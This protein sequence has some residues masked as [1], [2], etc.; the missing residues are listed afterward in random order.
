M[1]IELLCTALAYLVGCF[2]K[3]IKNSCFGWLL[4]SHQAKQGA[5]TIQR[6]V[7]L[8]DLAYCF[9]WLRQ[10]KQLTKSSHG[11]MHNWSETHGSSTNGSTFGPK[12]KVYLW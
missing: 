6:I 3:A 10:A 11:V 12:D 9:G 5:K 8:V 4:A 7:A 2:G 1:K